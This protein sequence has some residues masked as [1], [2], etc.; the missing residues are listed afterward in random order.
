[1]AMNLPGSILKEER[2]KQ[3]L[4]LG[5][6]S[7][8]TK[9]RVNFLSAIEDD[10]Y[11]VLPPVYIRSFVKSYAQAL[12]IP[13]I[14]IVSQIDTILNLQKPKELFI[15]PSVETSEP[16]DSQMIKKANG[17]QM[18]RNKYSVKQSRVNLI[19]YSI[20]SGLILAAIALIYFSIFSGKN[21]D[22]RSDLLGVESADT[23]NINEDK[24]E[25]GGLFSFLDKSES[26][27]LVLEAVAVDT[28]WLRI[29]MD[30][31]YSTGVTMYPEM[32]M[33]WSAMKYFIISLGNAGGVTFYRNGSKLEPFGKKGIVIR[34]LKITADKTES[35]A[36]PWN[37]KNEAKK[38]E[39]ERKTPPLIEESP[40]KSGKYN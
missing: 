37:K 33:R 7:D 10:N 15:Q 32:K 6:I 22:N 26:D 3:N 27:S 16:D 9:I 20:Y 19:N 4:S 25:N 13:Y 14:D 11:E 40:I 18:T 29:D 36:E 2:L 28:V 31:K 21:G 1:M 39:K 8:R 35:S 5:D 24:E 34:N 17:N 23:T 30:G 38:K 12:R